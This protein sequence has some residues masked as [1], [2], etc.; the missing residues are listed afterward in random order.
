MTRTVSEEM[1]VVA[2]S[3][4]LSSVN[5]EDTAGFRAMKEVNECWRTAMSVLLGVSTAMLA[6]PVLV[7]ASMARPDWLPWAILLTSSFWWLAALSWA[8][9]VVSLASG[10]YYFCASARGMRRAV[11]LAVNAYWGRMSFVSFERR[12]DW[13]FR[14]SIFATFTGTGLGIVF[15][16]C[17]GS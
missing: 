15:G 17:V 11:G 2:A 10:L 1:W 9:L 16:L 13:S 5:D 12:L 6:L 4:D 8:L 14:L 7:L 3:E